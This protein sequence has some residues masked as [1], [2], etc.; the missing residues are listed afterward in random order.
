MGIPP[1][2]NFFSE[3]FCV[4]SLVYLS[5]FFVVPLALMCLF[6]GVYCMFLYRVVNH[7]ACREIVKPMF[8]L[9]ERYLYSLI[10]SLRI[11]IGGFLFLSC[12][13]V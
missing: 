6:T 13:I 2:L 10:Y 8:N 5:V 11:L 4:G 3:V 7:G 12:F 9:R 1:S